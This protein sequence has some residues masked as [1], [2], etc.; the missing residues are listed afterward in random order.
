MNVKVITENNH[1][2]TSLCAGLLLMSV[3]AYMYFLT[4]SVVHVVLRQETSEKINLLRSEIALLESDY[5]DARH[6]ISD[7][8]VTLENFSLNQEKIFIHRGE[9]SLVLKVSS[10]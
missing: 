1:L 2:H 4:L 7:R 8:I 6:N 10:E 9:S 5:I 3:F